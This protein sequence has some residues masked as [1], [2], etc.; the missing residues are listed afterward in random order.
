MPTTN[1][2]IPDIQAAQSQKEV[3]AN[4]AHDLL[5]KAMNSLAVIVVTGAFSFTTVQTR[6]NAVI[7]LTGTPGAG[8]TADMPDTN[9]RLL[10]VV[11]NTDST[12]TIRN[13]AGAGSNNPVLLTLERGKFHYDGVDFIRLW[14]NLSP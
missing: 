11:N 4:Q 10:I 7:E 14:E 2:Q 8:F 5:D 9:A 6:E 12:A 1:L 3:T 13:S